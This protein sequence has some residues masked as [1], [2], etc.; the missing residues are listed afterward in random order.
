MSEYCFHQIQKSICELH[1]G[2]KN[3]QDKRVVQSSLEC[4]NNRVHL[5]AT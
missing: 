1:E 4:S 5:L 2:T 3:L